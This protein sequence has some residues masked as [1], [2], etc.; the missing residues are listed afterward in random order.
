[1]TIHVSNLVHFQGEMVNFSFFKNNAL[2]S[3]IVKQNNVLNLEYFKILLHS[4]F[5]VVFYISY[6]GYRK[7]VRFYI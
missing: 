2:K 5:L 7:I 1:M 3:E 4:I 6:I